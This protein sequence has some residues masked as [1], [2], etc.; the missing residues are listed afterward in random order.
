LASALL[1]IAFVVGLWIGPAESADSRC[2]H[3]DASPNVSV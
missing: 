2:L 1:N 3:G